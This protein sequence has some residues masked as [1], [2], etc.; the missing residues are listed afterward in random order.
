[1]LTAIK[2]RASGW[3]AWALV[4]LISIPFAL[5]GINSY[6]EGASK[7]VVASVNGVDVDEAIYQQALSEQR[8]SLVQMMGRN[9]DA[10]FF[11][12]KPFKLQALESLCNRMFEQSGW[13][14]VLDSD[15]YRSVRT[16]ELQLMAVTAADE[17]KRLGTPFP[18]NP[19]SP[20]ERRIVHLAV[21]GEAAIRTESEGYGE[22]RKVVIHPR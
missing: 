8:R 10:E 18:L 12:S 6:F 3:I 9:V 17:V 21:A 1:M 15:G 4:I 11:A 2:E 16:E 22:N 19:M 14:I 20:E 7:I 5:W 13:R